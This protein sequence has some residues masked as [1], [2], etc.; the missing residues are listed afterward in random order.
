MNSLKDSHDEE[1]VRH[2][3]EAHGHR[4]GDDEVKD[5][6]SLLNMLNG[7]LRELSL[8]ELSQITGS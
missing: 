7:G 6:L 4:V 2:I 5:I 3:L 8:D 1:S